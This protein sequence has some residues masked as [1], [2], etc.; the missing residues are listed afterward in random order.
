MTSTCITAESIHSRSTHVMLTHSAYVQLIRLTDLCT[1]WLTLSHSQCS[2]IPRISI[3]LSCAV[4]RDE[5]SFIFCG[6]PTLK[7]EN[8]G[9]WTPT[10][11]KN[12]DS[13]GLWL[14]T[15]HTWL[16]P[17][18]SSCIQNQLFQV[19]PGCCAPGLACP[20]YCLLGSIHR[21]NVPSKFVALVLV[22]TIF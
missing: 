20:L 3:Q 21:F 15:P 2:G 6:T 4:A 8:L 7:L 17:S 14:P 19:F 22:V 11:G 16:S 12:P 10:P 1:Y 13:G 5:E 18:P 9:L